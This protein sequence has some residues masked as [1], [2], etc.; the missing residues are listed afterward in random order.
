MNFIELVAA[1][2]IGEGAGLIEAPETQ[3]LRATRDW[4]SGFQRFFYG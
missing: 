1:E 3:E 2:I 4:T